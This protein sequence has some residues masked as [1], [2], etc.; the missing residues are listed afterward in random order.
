VEGA[1]D[2]SKL[3]QVIVAV[4][5]AVGF[6]LFSYLASPRKTVPWIICLS[7]FQMIDSP[8][9][10]STVMITFVVGIAYI[11]RGRLKYLPMLGFF[12]LIMG[13]YMASTGLADRSTYIQHAIYMFNY[14][15][16]ILM[17]FLVYNFVRETKD[18]DLVVRLLIVLNILVVIHSIIQINVG[19]RFAL[20]G[21][22]ELSIK[23]ARG[24]DD[25]RLSGPFGVGI[26]AELLVLSML[27]FAY[28]SIHIKSAMKRN[29]LYFLTALN[30]GCLVATANRGGF[31]ALVG[32][33]GLFLIMFR[34]EL[35]MKRTITLSVVGV[36]LLV[37][38]SVIVVN[39]TNYGQMYDR[40]AATELE[41]G[42]PDSRAV[43]WANI[44]PEIAKKPILGHGPRLRLYNDYAR[45][46][47]NTPL[48][49]YPH[50]LYLF[51]M[52]TVGAVGLGAYLWFF[53]W[54]IV[55]FRAG[56][57]QPSG[58]PF[59]D[60][61]IK[62]GIL[63]MIVFLVDEIKIEFLRFD[64]IDY[65]YY[66]FSVFAIFLGFADLARNGEFRRNENHQVKAADSSV[67]PAQQRAL[68]TDPGSR[69]N[70]Y[71]PGH[72]RFRRN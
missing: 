47:P 58:D 43:T 62:L 29:L 48:L 22:Q 6:F 19:P 1:A 57:R 40:L 36:F 21:I 68:P 56:I 11:L 46:Y 17:F 72:G 7:P 18:I 9:T 39:F 61:F 55:R 8:Y 37:V 33:A 30:L 50:D 25:P 14:V 32:G 15:S 20:F 4:V 16:A 5:L 34:R 35:G 27:L 51:L 53:A 44:V 71:S 24:G 49:H 60:G 52:Y 45:P 12:L 28:L 3:Y 23:G 63:S 69:K 54:L 13:I 64:Y 70:E 59:V 42:V 67:M 41:G 10:N 66:I 65:W 38:M 26:T 31:L 2:T